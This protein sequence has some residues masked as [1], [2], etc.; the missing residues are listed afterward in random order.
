MTPPASNIV[1]AARWAAALAVVV[2]VHAAAGAYWLRHAAPAPLVPPEAVLIDMAPAPP[3]APPEPAQ[4]HPPSPEPLPQDETPPPEQIPVPPEPPPPQPAPPQPPPPRP[5]PPRPPPRPGP[6]RP[7]PRAEPHPVTAP[8]PPAAAPAAPPPAP[9]PRAVAVPA[10]WTARLFAHIA[11]HKRY[12]PEAEQRRQQGTS[13]VRLVI[14]HAGNVLSARLE[15]SSGHA[16]LDAEALD[17]VRRS[18]PLPALPEDI[19]APTVEI[20]LPVGFR[21]R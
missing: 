5:T 8:A 15:Q 11:R 4:P 2:A 21:L 19:A 18:A 14:D 6:P 17:V 7:A 3:P 1:P 13:L 16:L 12:P 20:F 9:A 10:S